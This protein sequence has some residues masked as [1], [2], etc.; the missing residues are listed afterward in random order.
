MRRYVAT[1]PSLAVPYGRCPW[2]CPSSIG[3]P[4]PLTHVPAPREFPVTALSEADFCPLQSIPGHPV[5]LRAPPAHLAPPGL[6]PSRLTAHTLAPPP[7]RLGALAPKT[8]L[9]WPAPCGCPSLPRDPASLTSDRVASHTI[10][11]CRPYFRLH[12]PLFLVY[13]LLQPAPAEHFLSS[14]SSLTVHH[15][16]FPEPLPGL[17]TLVTL[18]SLSGHSLE[19]IPFRL[20]HPWFFSPSQPQLVFTP[21]TT[22]RYYLVPA[23]RPCVPPHHTYP[24]L[25]DHIPPACQLASPPD[26]T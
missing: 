16:P 20:T 13:L 12:P 4:L 2:I 18:W 15:Q 3:R 26:W 10:A 7:W 19:A 5:P 17:V 6:V 23:G 24:G 1:Y 22:R 11:P 9:F 14:S 8:L 21:P 25:S